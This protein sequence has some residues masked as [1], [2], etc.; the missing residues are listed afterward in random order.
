MN[1]AKILAAGTTEP[2]YISEIR[3][4]MGKSSSAAENA[5]AGYTIVTDDKGNKV[6]FNSKAGGGWGSKGEKVVYIGFKTTTEP[7][8][9]ITDIALMNMKGNYSIDDYDTLMDNYIKGQI[10]PFVD[11]FIVT[12]E[13]YRENYNSS[14]PENKKRADY[15]HDQL[16]EMTDDDCGGAGL[17]DLLLNQTKYEMGDDAYNAL[18][19]SEKKKHADIV[20][21]IAQ[22]NGKAT[23]ILENL[24]TRSAD[25]N[26]DSWID[27]FTAVTYDDLL[28][29]TGLSPSKAEKALDKHYY[30]DAMKIL[31]MW[32]PLREQLLGADQDE[33]DLKKMELPDDSEMEEKVRAVD[34]GY[35]EEK[36]VDAYTEVVKNATE[37]IKMY[38]KLCNVA[39]RDFLSSV[40]Y[41]DGTLYDFCTQTV[42]DV[43]SDITVLYPLVASLSEGQKAGL[44]F[45]SLREL[46]L[47][48]ASDENAYE[49]KEG[50]MFTGG[51]IYEGVD[52][53]IYEK[54]G[55]GLT[56]DAKRSTNAFSQS[57]SSD[58]LFHWYTYAMMGLT[59]ASAIGCI[60]TFIANRIVNV[61]QINHYSELVKNI[62]MKG[63]DKYTN[64]MMELSDYFQTSEL[65]KGLDT[66][67]EQFREAFN[68]FVKNTEAKNDEAFAALSHF[69]GRS[70]M[71]KWLGI[72]L[73]V[74]MILLSA[75]TTYLV[76]RDMVDHYKVEFTPIPRYMVDEKDITAFNKYGEKIVIK[77]Q[78]A[79]YKAALCNRKESDEYYDTVGNVADLNGDVGKQWLA[80][81]YA[82]NEAD[83]P[84]LADS[85][86][87]V[88]GD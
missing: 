73:G 83:M 46:V 14:F 17:G 36:M 50:K 62:P 86:K 10:I 60:T 56:S 81:Y 11:G 65:S 70:T 5:L 7:K 61:S 63:S 45:V 28:E 30:D 48:G 26:Q 16:N 27:R 72:G 2:V 24:L 31:D 21:I 59:G 84:I 82:K 80:I 43:E 33:E 37:R 44:E 15:I 3:V 64:Y 25:T 20:T 38:D 32:D 75:Y 39:A 12:L 18:S 6:D 69:Q 4:G 79:Y 13:E 54:G 88:T 29:E 77:N 19:D 85:L 41:E 1:P 51:S 78:A 8:I 68:K 9:A 71:C 23:L 47:I 53:G 74:A 49:N 40:E 52:R 22:A 42:E 87:V 34:E 35:S 66:T 57:D 58:S 76:Y 55:V 67:T